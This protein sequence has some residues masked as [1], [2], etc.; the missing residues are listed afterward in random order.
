MKRLGDFNGDG[1]VV[2]HKLRDPSA[3]VKTDAA[4]PLLG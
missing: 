1:K 3:S 2:A 4:N